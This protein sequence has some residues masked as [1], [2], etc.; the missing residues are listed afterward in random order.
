MKEYKY[1][2]LRKNNVYQFQ[3]MLPIYAV[4]REFLEACNKND[5]VIVKATAGSGK[6]TQLPQYLLEGME[7]RILITEPRAIAAESVA[8][9]VESELKHS[10]APKGTIGYIVGPNLNIDVSTRVVYMT[11]VTN[12][13]TIFCL[14]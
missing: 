4:K 8:K 2:Y 11:E 7:G 10:K 9:R 3:R 14:A 13:L 12:F 6:S 5:C 1:K